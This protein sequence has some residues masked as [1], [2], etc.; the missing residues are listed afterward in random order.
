MDFLFSCIVYFFFGVGRGRGEEG[1]N[2][3]NLVSNYACDPN[4]LLNERGSLI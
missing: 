3:P 1:S 4:R 2:A